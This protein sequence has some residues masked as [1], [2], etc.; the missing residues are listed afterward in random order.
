MNLAARLESTGARNRIQVSSATAALIVQSGKGKWLEKRK[1][2]VDIKGKG[3]METYFVKVTSADMSTSGKSGSHE[4][5]VLD[6]A[7]VP[8][9]LATSG[10]SQGETS[11][12]VCLSEKTCRL[13]DWNTEVL[14]RRIKA[15]IQYRESLVDPDFQRVEVDPIVTAQLQKYVSFVAASYRE[16]RFHNYEVSSVRSS[17]S[18]RPSQS[19]HTR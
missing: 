11:G 7:V 4:N 17:V 3:M 2:P 14:S 6:P 8:T 13:V 10:H 16:N 18:C 12:F 9:S 15:I 5:M 1:D 19:G